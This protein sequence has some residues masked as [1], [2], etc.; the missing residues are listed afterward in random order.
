M[1]QDLHS[2]FFYGILDLLKRQGAG[3][4]QE[5]LVI[6]YNK[7][8]VALNTSYPEKVNSNGGQTKKASQGKMN[9]GRMF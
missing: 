7:K 3:V 2:T 9:V 1:M 4:F 5:K 8:E 6:P